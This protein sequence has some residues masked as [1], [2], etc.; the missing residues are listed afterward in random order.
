MCTIGFHAELFTYHRFT[1]AVFDEIKR[2]INSY[3]DWIKS[4]VIVRKKI[5]KKLIS[6]GIQEINKSKTHDINNIEIYLKDI[7]IGYLTVKYK[8]EFNFVE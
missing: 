6:S 5:I 4:K 8:Y 7:N 2:K 3:I 1:I